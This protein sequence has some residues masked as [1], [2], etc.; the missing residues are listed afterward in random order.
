MKIELFRRDYIRQLREMKLPLEEEQWMLAKS[1]QIG[2]IRAGLFPGLVEQVQQTEE[3]K[4][5]RGVQT[6]GTPWAMWAMRVLVWFFLL[7]LL[8]TV[9]G[10][11]WL[12]Q[13]SVVREL[14]GLIPSDIFLKHGTQRD[15]YN[16]L[17]LKIFKMVDVFAL[18]FK[19]W[20]VYMLTAPFWKNPNLFPISP[21]VIWQ[22]KE[23]DTF[24]K[25]IKSF[26][27]FLAFLVLIF[28]STGG[29]F[30]LI[31][32]GYTNSHAPS[33]NDIFRN[34]VVL[35]IQVWFWMNFVAILIGVAISCCIRM[36]ID[37]VGCFFSP[38]SV[39]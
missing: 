25:I 21:L 16:I 7:E 5:S 22:N 18:P 9:S 35:N 34:N 15:E 26:W 33:R 19:I 37:F 11:R 1:I 39:S 3:R 38:R 28:L 30:A 31:F 10:A 6:H 2:S 8:I 24:Q 17:V 27:P 36:I 32:N 29:L 23:D 4:R 13:F 12:A 14:A 20:S